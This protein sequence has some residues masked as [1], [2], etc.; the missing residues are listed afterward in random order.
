MQRRLDAIPPTG[1]GNKG[2]R[3][4]LHDARRYLEKRVDKIRYG[5]LRRRDLV[6]ST[7]IVEGAVKHIVGRR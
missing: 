1:P 3:Q 4:R 5:S 7:G 2:R 6:I